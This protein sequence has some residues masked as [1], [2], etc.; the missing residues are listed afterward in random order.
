MVE[1]I[2][3]PLVPGRDGV[4][5]GSRSDSDT[6]FH[7][8]PQVI[9]D[10]RY[11]RTYGLPDIDDARDTLKEHGISH[12]DYGM[13]SSVA[14]IY[15]ISDISVEDIVLFLTEETIYRD[16]RRTCILLRLR[17][18][19]WTDDLFHKVMAVIV[20]LEADDSFVLRLFSDNP[21]Y[22]D[23]DIIM[24][25]ANAGVIAAINSPVFRDRRND[26]D[27]SY[28]FFIMHAGVIDATS[29]PD[30]MKTNRMCSLMAGNPVLSIL[31]EPD[32]P[33]HLRVDDFA[34]A[35]ACDGNDEDQSWIETIRF[36]SNN[37]SDHVLG[38]DELFRIYRSDRDVFGQIIR[39]DFNIRKRLSPTFIFR[40]LREN[41]DDH[42]L[43]PEE[44]LS[45]YHMAF[46]V[47][48]G[49]INPDTMPKIFR[50]I[51]RFQ[52]LVRK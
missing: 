33:C 44:K 17:D 49:K 39:D 20:A 15:G 16:E 47:N 26:T 27:L 19:E 25:F 2:R 1:N 40:V 18:S 28:G 21:A 43:F 50:L 29:V 31:N 37:V 14:S 32:A 42:V 4:N 22:L 48:S 34:P 11:V 41:P 45:I 36:W 30:A 35:F 5:D 46:L 51:P 6:L 13:T 7:E 52:K 9:L 8:A 12:P 10:P 23:D 3:K 24:K 38:E